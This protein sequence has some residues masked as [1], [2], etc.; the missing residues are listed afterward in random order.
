MAI[1]GRRLHGLAWCIGALAVGASAGEVPFHRTYDA[2]LATAKS[3]GRLILIFVEAPA[4]NASGGDICRLFREQLLANEQVAQLLRQRFAPMILDLQKVKDGEQKFPPVFKIRGQFRVPMVTVFS[5]EGEWLL[6]HEGFVPAET[7]LAKLQ[8]LLGLP[9]S[10]SQSATPTPPPREAPPPPREAP[11]IAEPVTLEGH[12]P[13]EVLTQLVR[14]ANKGT[15][16]EQLRL[17]RETVVAALARR[18]RTMAASATGAPWDKRDIG[19]FW[20]WLEKQHDL[21]ADLMLAI[22]PRDEVPQ[23]FGV[24]DRLRGK[25]PRAV[26]KWPHLVIAYAVVWDNPAAPAATRDAILWGEHQANVVEPETMEASFQYLIDS[27]RR[28]TFR[29]EQMRWPFLVYVADNECKVADRRW[30]L[31]TYYSKRRDLGPVYSKVPYDKEKLAGRPARIATQPTTLPNLLQYGGVCAEQAYFAS[32][33][34]KAFGVPAAPVTGTNRFGSRHAWVGY[35]GVAK[36][37]GRARPDFKFHGRYRLDHYYVGQV[38][39]PQSVTGVSDRDLALM[40]DAAAEYARYEQ[41]RLLWRVACW[42]DPRDKKLAARLLGAALK[43][44][45]Y[46][47]PAWRSIAEKMRNGEIAV[48]R[49]RELLKTMFS[50]LRRHPD[51][52]LEVL[53]GFLASIP[54][55]DV[56][57]R[58]AIYE[59]AYRLYA[60]RPDLQARLRLAQGRYLTE[61]GRAQQALRL[62]GTTALANSQEAVHILPLATAALDIY[63]EKRWYNKG[64]AFAEALLGKMPKHR[65]GRV[66]RPYVFFCGQL[67]RFC[68]D[69]GFVARSKKWQAEVDRLTAPQRL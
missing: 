68:K 35:F 61:H 56:K 41:A 20:A 22:C 19:E 40:F 38:I 66:S 18:Y 46:F 65:L 62:M 31:R 15:A 21:Y 54:E 28:L 6:M 52:T 25:F 33:V 3:E 55:T 7:L 8:D 26:I 4:K 9:K 36:S 13:E 1:N 12:L 34:C 2:A 11:H 23:V 43:A 29:P 67:S 5:V 48:S 50:R 27:W 69:A 58:N 14:I 45:H 10:P 16:P 57:A 53:E 30:A 42:I 37:R 51:L 64:V 60:K 24:V 39:D 63:R 47:G 44:N 59:R 17:L 49:S 32:R